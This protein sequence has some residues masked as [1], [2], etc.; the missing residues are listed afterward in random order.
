MKTAV[1]VKTQK[2]LNKLIFYIVSTDSI[3]E[4]FVSDTDDEDELSVV[5]ENEDQNVCITLLS[6][7]ILN[8][9]GLNLQKT[10]SDHF[11]CLNYVY[12]CKKR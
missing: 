4:D 2:P 8:V 3:E 1:I 5:V 6:K 9:E 7:V 11:E 12:L 10:C